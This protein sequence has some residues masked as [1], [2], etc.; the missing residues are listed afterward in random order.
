MIIIK[1]A[2]NL[3]YTE[4]FVPTRIKLVSI[5]FF[6]SWKNLELAPVL[7]QLNLLWNMNGSY[8]ISPQLLLLPHHELLEKVDGDIVVRRKKDAVVAREEVVYFALVIVLRSELFWGDERRLV[9]KVANLLHILIILLHLK[10]N[11]NV[12]SNIF[13]FLMIIFS[14]LRLI[15]SF[16]M[17]IYS[18]LVPRV[19]TFKSEQGS[20]ILNFCRL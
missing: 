16:L 9:P 8:H 17:V 11:F 13:S 14:F 4:T 19:P 1:I 2:S 10:N 5:E 3:L 15:Y 7:K 20:K 12:F 6:S 18:I